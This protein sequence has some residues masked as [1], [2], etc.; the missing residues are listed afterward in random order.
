MARHKLFD[1]DDHLNII[2]PDV[3][4]ELK[5][6]VDLAF[7][8]ITRKHAKHYQRAVYPDTLKKDDPVEC[9]P[10]ARTIYAP[11]RV[12][13]DGR[14]QPKPEAFAQ[15]MAEDNCS[16]VECFVKA[17]Y[18]ASAAAAPNSLVLSR[19]P[20]V[21]A[22][23]CQLKTQRWRLQNSSD[24]EIGELVSVIDEGKEP[25]LDYAFLIRQ[26]AVNL[27]L[28][29]RAGD[30]KAAN[31]SLEMLSRLSGYESKLKKADPILHKEDRPDAES[32]NHVVEDE[33]NAAEINRHAERETT[34]PSAAELVEVLLQADRKN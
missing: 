10:S 5:I 32:G 6:D 34:P 31:R 3:V 19:K 7:P 13:P 26:W 21:Y 27:D 29:R 23:I 20:E 16:V 17:G 33:I 9:A 15:F 1:D 4:S 8:D 11:Y 12:H 22:R 24:N 14:L 30:T 25:D 2:N 28:A 18:Q